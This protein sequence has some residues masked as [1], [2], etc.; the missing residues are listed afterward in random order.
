MQTLQIRLLQEGDMIRLLTQVDE[1]WLSG[2]LGGKKGF[3]PVNY[4]QVSYFV[5]NLLDPVASIN[6]NCPRFISLSILE[7]SRTPTVTLSTIMS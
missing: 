5:K 2:E 6:E 4:V 7:R 1:N 3:F